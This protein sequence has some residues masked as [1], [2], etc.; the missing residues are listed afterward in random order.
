M[1]AIVFVGLITLSTVAW[2]DWPQFRGPNSSG[3]APGENLPTAWGKAEGEENVA[4][5]RELPGRGPSSPIVVAGKVFVT[6]SSGVNQD[7]LHVLCFDAASG[8]RLW[9]R[10]FWATGRTLT[11]PTSA[12]AA[13]TPASDGEAVYAFFSS[14]DMVCLELDGALRWYRGLGLDYPK[15]GNDVGMSSSPVVIGDTVLVQV[16]AQGDSFV[17]GIDTKTGQHR[18][19][20]DRRPEAS[21]S[22][23]A[24]I[25]R[26]AVGRD[27][28]LFQAPRGLT[29]VDAHS[30][31]LLWEHAASCSGISSPLVEGGRVYVPAG[32]I[33]VLDVAAGAESA[34]V[35]WE[36][37]RLNPGAGSAVAHAGRIYAINNSGVL[38]CGDASNGD[39]LWQ[40]RL[41]GRCWATPI[42]TGE[43]LY[44][45]NS[46]GKAFVVELGEKGT[47]LATNDFGEVIQGTPAVSGDALFVRSDRYL[48]KIAAGKTP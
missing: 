32:G 7:R 1:R 2:A 47:I 23:P 36:S 43:R 45:F 46:D 6:C 13:P 15:A 48:W 37:P 44:A 35:A 21:W 33:T 12:N 24:V 4:W 14:S 3:L 16:E 18:W 9:E 25:S 26:E 20:F 30:G 41:E 27:V 8:E 34:A 19:R 17:A 42:I 5:R 28:A 31:E 39:V 29:A 38:V 10:Q 40:L 11:H 22:S